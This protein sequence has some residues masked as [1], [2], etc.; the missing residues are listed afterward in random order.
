MYK[1]ACISH[2][3]GHLCTWFQIQLFSNEQLI[4]ISILTDSSN[5]HNNH[6]NA[7]IQP[8]H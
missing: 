7:P 3:F 5:F 4:Q 2:V 8:I 6:T 1:I